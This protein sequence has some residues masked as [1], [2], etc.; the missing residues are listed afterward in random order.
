MAKYR[1]IDE[2]V[3]RAAII[4]L[5]TGKPVAEVCSTYGIS[6]QALYLWRQTNGINIQRNTSSG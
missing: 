5:K 6:K 3:K 1:R 2:N 4:E